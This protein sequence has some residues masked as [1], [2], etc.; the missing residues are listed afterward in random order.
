MHESLNPSSLQISRNPD[1]I[2]SFLKAKNVDHEAVVK[3]DFS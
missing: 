3:V 2:V 1:R